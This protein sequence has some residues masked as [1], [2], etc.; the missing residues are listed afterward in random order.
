MCLFLLE[1]PCSEGT[2]GY[3]D[4]GFDITSCR[5]CPP[6]N[7]CELSQMIESDLTADHFCT[8]GIICYGGLSDFN[9]AGGAVEC[10]EGFYCPELDSTTIETT[11]TG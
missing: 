3:T 10:P 5:A 8:D 11:L 2:V 7:V 1:V 9:V 4:G 6:G